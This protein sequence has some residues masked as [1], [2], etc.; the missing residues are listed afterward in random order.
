M[1]LPG[2]MAC[3]LKEVEGEGYNLVNRPIPSLGPGDAII[4][5]DRV[6]REKKT[7]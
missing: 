5:V 2:E 3:L 7:G 1:A 6:S 4:K